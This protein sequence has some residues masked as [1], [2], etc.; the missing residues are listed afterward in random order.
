MRTC[1]ISHLVYIFGDHIISV[2]SKI[3]AGNYTGLIAVTASGCN[4]KSQGRFLLG[5]LIMPLLF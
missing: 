1:D 3:T 2:A 5:N 4:A